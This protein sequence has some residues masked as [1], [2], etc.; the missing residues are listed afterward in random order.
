[1]NSFEA[2]KKAVAK[3]IV[4][5]RTQAGW[6]QSDVAKKLGYTDKA[7]SK[8]E[9][10]ESLPD[11]ATLKNLADIF[12]VTLDALSSESAVPETPASAPLAPVKKL[13][14]RN[15]LIIPVLSALL[16]WLAAVIA[17]V[18]LNIFQ[19]DFKSWLCFIYAIPASLIV[20]VV[21]NA[22]WGNKLLA[23]VIES[24]IIWSAAVCVVVT[25]YQYPD[26]PLMENVW[27]LMLIPIPLQLLAILWC[28]LRFKKR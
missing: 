16:A 15:K 8:W 5:L 9:R 20:L 26:A 10:A 6:T 22:V 23:C 2:I 3:N 17:F 19:A 28:V 18:L 7:V 13:L 25:C 1:M 14:T 21:F 24:L 4:R 27:M 12:G 11:I